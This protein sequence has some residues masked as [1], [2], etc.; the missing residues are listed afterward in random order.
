MPEFSTYCIKVRGQIAEDDLNTMS[1]LET[2]VI[3]ADPAATLFTIHTD[4]SGLIG[5][6]RHLHARGVVLLSLTCEP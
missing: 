3:R 6:I 5:L 4:Q 1:P 2:S